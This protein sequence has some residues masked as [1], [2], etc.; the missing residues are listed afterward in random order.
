MM[1]MIVSMMIPM[2]VLM[3]NPMIVWMMIPMIVSMMIPMIVSMMIPMIVSS[4]FAHGEEPYKYSGRRGHV[5]RGNYPAQRR[6]N[7]SPWH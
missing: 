3:M 4:S 6:E 5:L 7:S 1:S 2:I